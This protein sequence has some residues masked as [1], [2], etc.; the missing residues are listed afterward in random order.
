MKKTEANQIKKVINL[1]RKYSTYFV[2]KT[3]ELRILVY[4]YGESYIKY[5]EATEKE[6]ILNVLNQLSNNG[7]RTKYRIDHKTYQ[8][9]IH[10]T[11]VVLR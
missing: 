4:T 6:S 10:C 2:S 3:E 9:F 5:D 11:Y 8:G 1:K 7:L